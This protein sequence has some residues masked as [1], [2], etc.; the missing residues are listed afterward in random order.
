[1]KIVVPIK[2]VPETSNVKMDPERGT[3]IRANLQA[4][5]NPL[6]LYAVEAALRLKDTQGAQV[7]VISMGPPNAVKALKEA[8]AMGCDQGVLICNK[9]FGG[10]DTWATA[11]TLASAIR[12]LGEVDLIICGERATDGD[13][14][15]VG[16]GIASF[17]D[18]PLATY[19]SRIVDV[20]ERGLRV[21]RLVEG[22]RERLWS[23]LPM[24]LTVLKDIA[25]P[26]L[27]TL[28]GMRRAKTMEYLT[29]GPEDIA[30]REEWIG[31]KGSPT[32]VV[33]IHNAKVSRNGE[34]IVVKTPQDVEAAA[35][36]FV[37]FVK[38]RHIL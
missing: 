14:G 10:A 6:D 28:S 32:R 5:M 18:L 24:V 4:I 29:W 12:R 36:A 7:T 30:A 1:M 25:S 33:K 38:A 15:Q 19:V 34:K 13:T 11:Y 3:M 16:P 2:Q 35:E 21:E 27:P 9:R 26:R 31:L 22:G 23:P 8:V 37:A 17:L 20:D